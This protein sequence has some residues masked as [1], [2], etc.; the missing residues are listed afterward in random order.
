MK[1]FGNLFIFCSLLLITSC[2]EVG[3]SKFYNI[4]AVTSA[5]E[6]RDFPIEHENKEVTGK[7]DILFV[8]DNS[9]S[10]TEEQTIL[11]QSFTNFIQEFSQRNIDFQIG[12]TS[13]DN[14]D[15]NGGGDNGELLDITNSGY[16]V[17]DRNTPN[18]E[19]LFSSNIQI[20]T[21]GFFFETP[22]QSVYKTLNGYTSLSGLSLG[23]IRP[24]AQLAIITFSDEDDRAL[25]IEH[26]ICDGIT[27]PVEIEECRNDETVRLLL[28]SIQGIKQDVDNDIFYYTFSNSAKNDV[29]T[30]ILS[31]LN[32]IGVNQTGS[33]DLSNNRDFSAD[34]VDIGEILSES[35]AIS[36]IGLNNLVINDPSTLRVF[37]DEIQINTTEYNLNTSTGKLEINDQLLADKNSV[38][39]CYTN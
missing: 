31:E 32:G 27:D 19:S 38:K 37:V 12:I 22:S 2:K 16:Y 14:N 24:E 18:Y 28:D 34:L 26:Q 35:V 29:H 25:S 30:R 1:L 3:E 10:M 9:D 33:Y 13:T 20:G 15:F 17:I 21:G 7:I 36:S 8:V 23:L 5:E 4:V 6:C 11:A 39:V